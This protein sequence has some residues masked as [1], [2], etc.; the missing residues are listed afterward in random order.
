MP[1]FENLLIEILKEVN[2]KDGNKNDVS[3]VTIEYVSS[4]GKKKLRKCEDFLKIIRIKIIKVCEKNKIF[5]FIFLFF[6]FLFY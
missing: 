2:I 1:Y 3:D 6:Y 4:E 5:S